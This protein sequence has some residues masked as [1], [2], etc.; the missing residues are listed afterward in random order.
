[1]MMKKNFCEE[2]GGE[3]DGPQYVGDI[4]PELEIAVE[5]GNLVPRKNSVSQKVFLILRYLQS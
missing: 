3:E 1:M 5:L 4:P 2:I